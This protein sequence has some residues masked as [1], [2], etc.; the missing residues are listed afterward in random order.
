LATQL[1]PNP[2]PPAEDDDVWDDEDDRAR[3]PEAGQEAADAE[4]GHGK[5]VEPMDGGAESA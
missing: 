1:N 3:K 4:N 2:P 5:P